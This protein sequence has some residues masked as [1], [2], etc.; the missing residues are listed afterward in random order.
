MIYIIKKSDDKKSS[1]NNHDIENR[2]RW[3]LEI[4]FKMNM[5]LE[6]RA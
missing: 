5:A 6:L 1:F 3:K 2:V 4:D